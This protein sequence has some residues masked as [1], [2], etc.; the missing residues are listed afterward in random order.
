ML[1]HC[2]GVNNLNGSLFRQ[3]F[4]DVQSRFLAFEEYIS[5]MVSA[6]QN[7]TKVDREIVDIN[8]EKEVFRDAWDANRCPCLSILHWGVRID[9]VH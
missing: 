4:K 7:N 1:L 8:V 3:F 5:L 6:D 9:V 2:T